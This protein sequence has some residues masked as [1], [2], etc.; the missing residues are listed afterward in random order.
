MDVVYGYQIESYRV[1][2]ALKAEN[3]EEKIYCI[4]RL[5]RNNFTYEIEQNT[6]NYTSLEQVEI[7]KNDEQIEPTKDNQFEYER[8]SD[9]K[10]CQIY[11]ERFCKLELENP[12]EAYEMIDEEYKKNR[13]TSLN[14]Y[15][16]YIRDNNEILKNGKLVKYSYN[17][18][19]EYTEC[20]LVDTYNN[21]YE[22]IEK[23]IMDY[24]I[25][26][27]NYTIKLDDYEEKYQRMSDESKV[28][29]NVHIFI[30]MINTKDYKHAYEL[31]D[32]TFRQNN[33]NN[34][35]SFEKYVKDNFYNINYNDDSYDINTQNDYYTCICKIKNSNEENAQEKTLNIVMQL[36][37][38]TDFVMSFSFE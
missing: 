35:D 30:Q 34:I 28:A 36:K 4:V 22:I 33:F 13:F 17:Y 2:G 18:K 15:I 7:K 8:V 9:E 3:Q 31:L 10:L 16:E 12:V 19:D 14:E 32:N 38:G 29:A 25:K 26:L 37:E 21:S 11:Y 1:Y 24:T 20:I 23:G 6:E 27:D 5:D